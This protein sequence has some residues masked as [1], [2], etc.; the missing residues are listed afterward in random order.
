MIDSMDIY[1]SLNINI[2]AVMKNS[3]RLTFVPDCLKIK[4][5]YKHAAK[6]LPYLLRYVPYQYKT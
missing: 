2:R 4:K 1:T 3:E 5:M 6:K